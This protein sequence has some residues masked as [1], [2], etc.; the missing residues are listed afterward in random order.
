MLLPTLSKPRLKVCFFAHLSSLLGAE[1]MLLDLVTDL[2]ADHGVSCLVILPEPGPLSLALAQVGAKCLFADYGWWCH[3]DQLDH[4]TKT[5]MVSTGYE[6]LRQRLLPAL[7]IFDPDVIWTQTMVIPWGALASG[8]LNKPHIWYI[9]ELGEADHGFHFFSPFDAVINDIIQSSDRIFTCSHFVADSLFSPQSRQRVDVLYNHIR[10]P[11]IAR[12]SENLFVINGSVRIGIFSQVNPGKGTEDIVMSATKLIHLG[13]NIEL[14]VAG[15][16][17]SPAYRDK[18]ITFVKG[19][20][21]QDRIRFTGF[22][23]DP[24][25]AMMAVDICAVCS[26]A[27]AFGRVGVEAMLLGKPVVY[28]DAGGVKEYMIDGRTGLSYSP[29]DVDGLAYQLGKLVNDSTRRL[30][31]GEAGR[32]HASRL[33]TKENYSGTALSALTALSIQGRKVTSISTSVETFATLSGDTVP[34]SARLRR[35]DP[36][37]CGSGK[38]FKHCHGIIT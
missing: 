25:S 7:K 24:F 34:V 27:E 37:P 22:L 26:R 4:E 14:L 23:N 17:H 16:T 33:F 10:T 35:N 29:G 32:S 11:E 8:Y 6:L 13:S 2:W 19:Q 1:R 15:G 38:R 28:A 5:R 31:I 12:A 30:S 9:T 3:T 21:L 36:C 20:G 18:L